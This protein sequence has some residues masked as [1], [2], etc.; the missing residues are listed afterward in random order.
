[1]VLHKCDTPACVNPDHLWL[2]TNTDNMADRSSKRRSARGEGHGLAKL[3]TTQ[4]AEIR[5]KYAKGGV[6]QRALAD[7][8]SVS[9]RTVLN[10]HKN[11]IW[12]EI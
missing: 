1:M 12:K 11:Q 4:A 10:I 2:G 3:T 9:Q 5:A 7:E 6:S 8:Y